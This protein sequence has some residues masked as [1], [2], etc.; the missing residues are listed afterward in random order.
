MAKTLP[1]TLITPTAVAFDG[2]A[3]LVI[4]IGTEGEVGILPDHAPY[5][6]SLKPGVLRADVADGDSTRRLIM[7]TS[8]GFMQALPDQVRVVVDAALAPEAIDPDVAKAELAAALQR[9]SELPLE[10]RVGFAREQ[11]LIDFANAKLAVHL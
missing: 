3:S 2:H 6:T 11:E 10:D 8:S 7:A 5:L 1:F 4:A 9:Q